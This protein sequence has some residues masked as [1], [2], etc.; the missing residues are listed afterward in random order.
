[1]AGVS[2]DDSVQSLSA[3]S[4]TS[5]TTRSRTDVDLFVAQDHDAAVQHTLLSVVPKMGDWSHT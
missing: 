5:R 2:Q 1:M 3:S 4:P